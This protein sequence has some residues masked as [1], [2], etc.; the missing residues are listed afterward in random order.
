MLH[1]ISENSCSFVA[2]LSTHPLGVKIR[3]NLCPRYPRLKLALQLSK[4]FDKSALFMQNKADVKIGKYGVSIAKIKDYNNK[5]RTI[6]PLGVNNERNS[7]QSQFVPTEVGTKPILRSF[8]HAQGRLGS[9]GR[10]NNKGFFS[11]S[12]L[13]AFD[14]YGINSMCR[15]VVGRV[16]EVKYLFGR[17]DGL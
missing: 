9:A 13:N 5:Q 7:K 17:L 8:D 10:L 6:Y 1:I 12:L 3:V 15:A 11:L 2:N 4:V 16:F 14:V